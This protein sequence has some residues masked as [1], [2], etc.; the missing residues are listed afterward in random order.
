[1]LIVLK[2]LPVAAR[3]GANPSLERTSCSYGG[4]RAAQPNR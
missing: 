1:M 3:L 4:A 2:P